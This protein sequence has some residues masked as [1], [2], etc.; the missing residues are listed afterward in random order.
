MEF[1]RSKLSIHRYQACDLDEV[2]QFIAELNRESHHHIAYYGVTPAE[3]KYYLLEEQTIPPEESYL[4]AIYRDR[5]YGVIGLEYDLQLKRAWIEG[6]LVL[7]QFWGQIAGELYKEIQQM[8]PSPID[9][10]ELAGDIMNTNLERLAHENG[11][12]NDGESALLLF[13]REFLTGLDQ[14][15]AKLLQPRFTEQCKNL[16]DRLF[17]GTYYNGTQ[18][19][20][21]VDDLHK[22]FTFVMQDRLFGYVFVYVSPPIGDAYIDFIGVEESARGQGIGK[23]LLVSALYWIFLFPEIQQVGLTVRLENEAAQKMYRSAGFIQERILRG[24]RKKL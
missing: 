7:D 9:D 12:H 24:Y 23:R 5:L 6:P 14:V 15:E 3:I 10:Y 21:L 11:Y 4:K 8:V 2:S 18:L 20:D 19:V 1:Y 16:H 22:V 17:P 13:R